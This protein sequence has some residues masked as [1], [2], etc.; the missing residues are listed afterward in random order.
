[1][2]KLARGQDLGA[3]VRDPPRRLRTR[4]GTAR[5]RADTDAD[6][7]DRDARTARAGHGTH[8][9]LVQVAVLDEAATADG[10]HD[11]VRVL[12]PPATL[13]RRCRSRTPT[14]RPRIEQQVVV[15]VL[16]RLSRSRSR[17]H[18]RFDD[19]RDGK[20]FP[21]GEEVLDARDQVVETDTTD[22][23]FSQPVSEL[24]GLGVSQSQLSAL[25]ACTV[26]TLRT[27][28]DNE[29]NPRIRSPPAVVVAGCAEVAPRLDM[30]M[31][32]RSLEGKKKKTGQRGDNRRRLNAKTHLFANSQGAMSAPASFSARSYSAKSS[33]D[34]PFSDP[35]ASIEK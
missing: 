25:S 32:S 12:L 35:L 34:K 18:E 13:R 28:F 29:L 31:T 1:M 10:E 17:V 3:A 15:R 21:R 26:A 6:A 30:R 11:R 22:A 7:A 23:A 9:V 5:P 27:R 2:Y 16:Q 20:V 4:H 8:H 24:W 19:S 33:R 14:A